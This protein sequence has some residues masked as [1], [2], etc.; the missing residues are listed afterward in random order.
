MSSLLF[1]KKNGKEF[2][3]IPSSI[4]GSINLTNIGSLEADACQTTSLSDYSM[5]CQ[6]F[7][8]RTRQLIGNKTFSCINCDILILH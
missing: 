8:P 4:T 6:S 1:K 3:N 2:Q 7:W 5:W